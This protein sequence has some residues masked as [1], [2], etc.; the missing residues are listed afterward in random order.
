MDKSHDRRFLMVAEAGS[1]C[2]SLATR[3]T[4]RPASTERPAEPTADPTKKTPYPTMFTFF[5]VSLEGSPPTQYSSGKP[6]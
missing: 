1:G 2:A 5:R 3:L 4:R 6:L